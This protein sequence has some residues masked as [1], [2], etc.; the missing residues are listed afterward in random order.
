MTPVGKDIGYL[1]GGMQEKVTPW[2][3]PFYDNFLNCGIPPYEM[4]EMMENGELEITP[5]TFI[6]GRSISNAIIIID[7]VQNLELKVVKQ[8]ISRAAEGSQV[9]LLGDETQSFERVQTQCIE[10][11]V[12]KGKDS[13]LVGHCDLQKSLRS[14]LAEWAGKNL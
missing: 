4:E 7:E 13:R 2:L 12:E 5:I 9:I 8:V 1:K 11:L 14:P 10:T 6:Q 3:G